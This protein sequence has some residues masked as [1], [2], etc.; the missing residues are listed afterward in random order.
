MPMTTTIS[1]PSPLE[2]WIER[3]IAAGEYASAQAYVEALIRRDRE[4]VETR[5]EVVAALMRGEASGISRRRVPDILAAI[6][7]Q[8]EE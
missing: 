4:E 7:V 8:P 5:E 2:D 6:R 1:V 3:R